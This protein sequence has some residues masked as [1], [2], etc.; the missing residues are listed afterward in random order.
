MKTEKS[1]RLAVFPSDHPAKIRITSNDAQLPRKARWRVA[2][3]PSAKKLKSAL[4]KFSLSQHITKFYDK[5]YL[6]LLFVG[7]I[8]LK[9][10][11]KL[12]NYV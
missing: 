8:S 3:E 12:L 4:E 7:S 5:K 9:I 10:T 2:V 11:R 1:Q 6:P